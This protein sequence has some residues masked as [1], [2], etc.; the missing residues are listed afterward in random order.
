MKSLKLIS[1]IVFVV[2]VTSCKQSDK[3]DGSAAPSDNALT[4][5]PATSNT[6]A[7]NANPVTT[8]SFENIWVLDSLNGKKV[9]QTDFDYGSPY[10]EPNL[11]KKTIEGHTGC[12]SFKG[13]LKVEDNKFSIDSLDVAKMACKKTGFHTSFMNALKKGSISYKVKNGNLYVNGGKGA[14]YVFR[15]IRR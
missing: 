7:V 14:N 10:L 5:A 2:S 12:S 15:P 4:P 13:I 3:Q 11:T 9:A 8:D 1:V 6:P